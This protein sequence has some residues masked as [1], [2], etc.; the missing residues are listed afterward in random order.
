MIPRFW[1]LLGALAAVTV[2]LCAMSLGFFRHNMIEAAVWP[3]NALVLTFLLVGFKGLR[4]RAAALAV[5]VSTIAATNFAFGLPP[6][7]ALGFALAN[8]ME[9]AVA[10]WF[11][12][13]LAMPMSEPRDYLRFA[14]G[15][16]IAG[17]IVGAALASVPMVA[18]GAIHG[19]DVVDFLVR[20]FRAD[21]LGMA[22]CAPFALTVAARGVRLPQGRPLLRGSLAQLLVL[23]FPL[24]AC[25]PFDTPFPFSVFI[26]PAVAVAVFVSRD[27]GGLLA[28][29]SVA[30]VLT[31]GAALGVGPAAR[32]VEVGADGMLMV[33]ALLA[34]LVATVHPLSAV[35]R[36]LDAYAAD[37]E[38]RR[39]RA[40][41][42][43]DSKTRFLSVMSEELRSPLTGVLTVAELLKSG[44]LGSLTPKQRELMGHLVES[45][46]QIESVTRKLIDAAAL[47]S[48]SRGVPGERFSL[49]GLMVSA[50]TAA[51]FR[52]RRD[53]D[54]RLG[55]AEEELEVHGD[56]QRLRQS[57]I[58]LITDA[59][60]FCAKPGL[61]QVSAFTTGQG[62][63]RIHIEDDGQGVPLERLLELNSASADTSGVG[64]GLGLTRDLIRLQGGDLGVESGNLGG[65][66]VW[67]D[68]PAAARA[69]KAA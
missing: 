56:P 8:G 6:A 61:V 10:A 54:I 14:G 2:A 24:M 59:A 47:Q 18:T 23:A 51:R 12:R 38:A 32:A 34:A 52:A 55:L 64:V 50:V 49:S 67:I 43:S 36:R 46:E 29:M 57:L 42:A 11:L 26:F 44:R 41:T 68:L 63:V 31:A 58:K 15:A 66:R 22:V 5:A 60:S 21:A 48:G 27:V 37:A 30:I 7:M 19:A 39:Q 65:A 13:A 45:G 33:Q 25:L 4:Q 1:S 53:C 9:I 69:A 3:A 28:V 17:P 35:L 20:W 62:S 16:I 40:E